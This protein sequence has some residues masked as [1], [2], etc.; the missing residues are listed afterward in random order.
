MPRRRQ[1]PAQQSEGDAPE[2]APSG[3]DVAQLS[4]YLSIEKPA[5]TTDDLDEIVGPEQPFFVGEWTQGDEDQLRVE[6]DGSD[7]KQSLTNLPASLLPPWKVAMRLFRSTPMS[8][9]SPLQ[10]LMYQP[11]PATGRTYTSPIYYLV[12]A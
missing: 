7:E 2:P 3:Q 11:L 4:V 8:I 12:Y 5:V 10:N 1:N 6:W 9:I